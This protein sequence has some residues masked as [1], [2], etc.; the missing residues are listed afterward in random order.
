MTYFVGFGLADGPSA[1]LADGLEVL[2]D[3]R[4]GGAAGEV[5]F[6]TAGPAPLDFLM[7][8]LPLTSLL[9]LRESDFDAEVGRHFERLLGRLPERLD[10]RLL[11]LPRG[12]FVAAPPS[13]SM[14]SLMPL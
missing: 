11:L 6:R 1:R 7:V 9:L 13:F 14:S 3:R 10:E 2:L 4:G 12:G 8:L 5:A